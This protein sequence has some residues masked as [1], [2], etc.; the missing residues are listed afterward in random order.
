MK[1]CSLCK[2]EQPKSAFHRDAGEA[3]GL[4]SQCKECA[5]AGIRAR[6]HSRPETRAAK[7]AKDAPRRQRNA[8]RLSVLRRTWDAANPDRARA[9]RVASEARHPEAVKARKALRAAVRSGRVTREP[10]AACGSAK[11][12][13]GHHHRGYARAHWY[14][15]EW[16]CSK[17]HAAAHSAALAASKGGAA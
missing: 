10:C 17:C 8:V 4:K 3:C 2:R 13:H 1:R 16:L 14:D 7:R 11:R 12:V 9:L 6:W 15:V 5:C